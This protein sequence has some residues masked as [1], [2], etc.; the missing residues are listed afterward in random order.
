MEKPVGEDN[1]SG[2]G[3]EGEETSADGIKRLL[4]EIEAEILEAEVKLEG[5][6]SEKGVD[7]EKGSDKVDEYKED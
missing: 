1:D 6:I 5:K 3:R 2:E 7:D 4:L